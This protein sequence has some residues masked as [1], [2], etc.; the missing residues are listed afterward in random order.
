MD[1][2]MMELTASSGQKQVN[3]SEGNIYEVDVVE[4]RKLLNDAVCRLVSWFGRHKMRW[5]GNIILNGY[6]A[7]FGEY[8]TY[9]VKSCKKVEGEDV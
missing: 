2:G 4:N 7:I 9:R 3:M 5:L 8:K 1:M 6:M